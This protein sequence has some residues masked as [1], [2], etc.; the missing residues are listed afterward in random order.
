[1]CEYCNAP[2]YIKAQQFLRPATA[3][4][5][6]ADALMDGYTNITG[7]AF[8]PLQKRFCPICGRK[9][10]EDDGYIR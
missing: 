6:Y 7:T 10:E 9:M 8:V 3:P 2:L 1:M 4:L 5:T